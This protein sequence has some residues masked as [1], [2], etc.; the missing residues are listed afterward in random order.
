MSVCACVMQ[1][2]LR[3]SVDILDILGL[4]VV[5]T[6]VLGR[7]EMKVMVTAVGEWW[8]GYSIM[9]KEAPWTLYPMLGVG[10]FI[11]DVLVIYNSNMF[12]DGVS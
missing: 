6:R 3:C 12:G 8:I 11:Y 9:H 10:H 7:S 1:E 5:L 2:V 4:Y